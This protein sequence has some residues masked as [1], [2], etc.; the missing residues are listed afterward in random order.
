MSKKKRNRRSVSPKGSK[1][2]QS[3]SS[4]VIPSIVGCVVIVIIV[5]AI[6]SIENQQ[7]VSAALPG[8]TAGPLPTNPPPYPGVTRI[9]LQETREKTDNGQ[10]VLIDVRSESSY[11]KLHA[12]GAFSIPEQEIE[13]RLDELPRDKEVILYCT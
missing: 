13:G 4:L 11:D 5:G 3:A 8:S 10:A 2:K 1:K 7:P 12:K 6:L 9:S